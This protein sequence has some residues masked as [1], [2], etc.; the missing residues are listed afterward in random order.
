[1]PSISASCFSSPSRVISTL[2][3][4]AAGDVADGSSEDIAGT[5]QLFEE[6]SRLPTTDSAVVG[7][8]R[9]LLLLDDSA[10]HAVLVDSTGEINDGNPIVQWKCVS[11]FGYSG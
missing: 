7:L 9:A 8:T 3:G 10:N 2:T 6:T 5:G 1:M 11:Q 4:C